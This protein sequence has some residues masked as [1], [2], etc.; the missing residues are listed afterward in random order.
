MMTFRQFLDERDSL[1]GK[2]YGLGGPSKSGGDHT[3]T[4][5]LIAKALPK[6]VNPARPVPNVGLQVTHIYGGR[7]KSG[8]IGQ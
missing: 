6:V 1:V 7:K 2:M 3:G 4:G 8:I 5:K